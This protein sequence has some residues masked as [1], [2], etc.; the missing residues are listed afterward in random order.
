RAMLALPRIPGRL[1]RMACVAL[2][3]GTVSLRRPQTAD[4]QLA[5]SVA[6]DV[7]EVSEVDPP[8]DV[9]RCAGAC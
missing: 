8:A 9:E 6:L 7:V 5:P 3:F 1:A 4:R 2:R